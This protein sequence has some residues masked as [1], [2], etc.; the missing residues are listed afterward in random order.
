MTE[1]LENRGLDP[2]Q[3]YTESVPL[4]YS[5]SWIDHDNLEVLAAEAAEGEFGERVYDVE[6][7]VVGALNGNVSDDHMRSE[8]GHRFSRLQGAVEEKAKE[9][10]ADVFGDELDGGERGGADA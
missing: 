7:A 10:R 9:Y 1:T 6:A 4:P 2:E 5:T 3:D 8:Y